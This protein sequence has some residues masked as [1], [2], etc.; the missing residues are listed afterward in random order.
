MSKNNDL[1]AKK[2]KSVLSSR[3]LWP[4]SQDKTGKSAPEKP[5]RYTVDMVDRDTGELLGCFVDSLGHKPDPRDYVR[6]FKNLARAVAEDKTW[7]ADIRIF[8]LL[9]WHLEYGNF[10]AVSQRDIAKYLQV[11]RDTVSR[12]IKR[13]LGAQIIHADKYKGAHGYR[14]NPN[15]VHMGTNAQQ[16]A[17]RREWHDM[18]AA[19]AEADARAAETA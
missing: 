19:K 4:K 9:L 17:R 2:A 15:S 3:P 6:L 12:I 8:M 13:M 10:L 16:A 18:L 7:P 11:S 14:L 1:R 5:S